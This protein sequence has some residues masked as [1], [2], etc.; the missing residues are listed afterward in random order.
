MTWQVQCSKGKKLGAATM[1]LC[2]AQTMSR[3]Q[4]CR[5]VAHVQLGRLMPG[6]VTDTHS[7]CAAELMLRSYYFEYSH[8][9]LGWPT[10]AVR[11]RPSVLTDVNELPR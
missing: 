5:Y 6:Y 2:L 1:T 9:V 3:C 4:V 8:G 10:H 7:C 11:R